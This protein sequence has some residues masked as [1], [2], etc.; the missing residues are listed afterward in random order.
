MKGT[1]L[2]SQVDDEVLEADRSGSEDEEEEVKE[3][4]EGAD[5]DELERMD[6]SESSEGEQEEEKSPVVLS[7]VDRIQRFVEKYV[8]AHHVS[9]GYRWTGSREG[10]LQA[11]IMEEK[12][13]DMV[14]VMIKRIKDHVA[15]KAV[16]Q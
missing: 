13:Q 15:I 10:Q 1:A 2:L 14:D 4:E 8:A 5:S 7:A 12:L 3:G 9:H 6:D 11:A 16:A